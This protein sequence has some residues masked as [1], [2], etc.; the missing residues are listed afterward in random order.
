MLSSRHDRK[1]RPIQRR[2]S[3]E[4]HERGAAARAQYAA[5]AAHYG[6]SKERESWRG[7]AGSET[8]RRRERLERDFRN[9]DTSL[10]VGEALA[11]CAPDRLLGALRIIDAQRDPL[12]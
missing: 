3:R 9:S 8:R 6:S 2:G 12:V 10:S 11:G 1:R 4:A 7:S 5:A